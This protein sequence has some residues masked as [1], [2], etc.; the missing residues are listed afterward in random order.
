MKIEK[1]PYITPM[2]TIYGDIDNITLAS[3]FP[4]S[5]DGLGTNTAFPNPS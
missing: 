3:S 2:L 1:K 5:D 4:N